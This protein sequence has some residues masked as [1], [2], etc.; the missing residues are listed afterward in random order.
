MKVS[1]NKDVKLKTAWTCNLDKL[2]HITSDDMRLYDLTD[3]DKLVQGSSSSI[4]VTRKD[5]LHVEV[6]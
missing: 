1:F 5:K 6:R 4:S 2:C 3:I